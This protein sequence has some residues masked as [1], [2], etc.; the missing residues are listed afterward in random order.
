MKKILSLCVLAAMAVSSHA[1]TAKVVVGQPSEFKN[2]SE[3]F[4]KES[5]N[6]TAE[7]FNLVEINQN[8]DTVGLEIGTPHFST[9]IR[10]AKKWQYRFNVV[11]DDKKVE[12][13]MYRLDFDKKLVS[14]IK[15]AS[16]DCIDILD[17]RKVPTPTV[18]TQTQVVEKVNIRGVERA[19]AFFALDKSSNAHITNTVDWDKLAS[20]IKRDKP[21]KV[22]LSAYTDSSGSY[23]HNLELASK[24]A[25]T[26]AQN[27]IKRGIQASIIEVNN[28]GKTATF[29]QRKVVVS[30]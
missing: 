26:V 6:I 28:V 9:G 18:I 12:D 15:A 8:K 23:L 30:W 17:V 16:Q 21:E 29:P 22:Y 14:A 7:Q 20:E 11:N 3:S 1:S 25:D 27:L 2:L 13:C 24:R 10:A 4:L 19:E 5:P